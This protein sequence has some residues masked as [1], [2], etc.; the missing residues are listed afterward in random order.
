MNLYRFINFKKSAES[1][2][3]PQSR[4]HQVIKPLSLVV[5][6]SLISFGPAAKAA[7]VPNP[8]EGDLFLAFRADQEPGKGKSY[9]VKIGQ[10]SLYK[11]GGSF[12]VSG[13][14]SIAADLVDTFGSDWNTRAD[15]HWSVF[16]ER[17]ASNA[18]STVYASRER[19][20]STL[21]S[22]PWPSLN[23][24]ARTATS[25]WISSVV[26]GIYGYRGSDATANSAVA[27]VQ[28]P[29]QARFS[30]YATQTDSRAKNGEDGASVP[31]TAGTTQF[32][33]LSRWDH[34][35]GSIEG[36]FEAG[37]AG[38]FLDLYQISPAGVSR[39]GTFSISDSGVLSFSLIT[40]VP[41]SLDTDGD[42][43]TDLAEIKAG[44]STTDA[45]DYL[46]IGSF[47]STPSGPQV[48]ASTVAGKAYHLE[49]SEDLQSW[50]PIAYQPAGEEATP[51]DFVD[52][53]VVRRS[54][55][56]GFY[57]LT[58]VP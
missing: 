57:R 7:I 26:N 52:T 15:V 28:D 58:V 51:F 17:V 32:G 19:V 1:H 22:T 25:T 36:D 18:T 42:G 9:I 43:A 55:A 31:L 24:Q 21:P 53:D 13:L 33:G 39:L 23:H 49:Y 2:L 56:K 40:E 34:K 50:F 37:T 46:H 38:S 11:V 44:T 54:K 29:G 30:N 41:G 4:F 6:M 5:A 10:D 45:T 35:N 3:A 48:T 20:S 16:G 8:A 27:T 47:V 12:S 14:G